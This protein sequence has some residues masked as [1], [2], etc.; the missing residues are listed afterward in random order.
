MLD[1]GNVVE[2]DTPSA[3]LQDQSSMFYSMVAQTGAQEQHRLMNSVQG[4]H[5]L[6]R[7]INSWDLSIALCTRGV[8]TEQKHQLMT[9]I[10][11]PSGDLF[12]FSL[13]QQQNLSSI[14]LSFHTLS[15][16][17]TQHVILSPLLKH[18]CISSSS[19]T[20]FTTHVIKVLFSVTSVIKELKPLNGGRLFDLFAIIGL[21]KTDWSNG[22]FW[23]L[24]R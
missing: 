12:P 1:S 11:V 21:K 6:N 2:F 14:C 5:I 10:T 17:L 7:S 20:F 8:H 24:P 4:A 3:L 23:K 9:S 13:C 16:I 22:F 19:R 18:K 15:Y